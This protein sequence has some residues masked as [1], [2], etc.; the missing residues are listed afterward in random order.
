MIVPR[1]TVASTATFEG[2]GLHT[3]VPVRVDIHSGESGIVF[4]Y[5]ADTVRAHPSNVTDTRRCTRL[6]TI[7]TIEHLMSAL[8][9]TGVTDAEIELSAPELPGMDGSARPFTD[10][11]VAAGRAE[12][13]ARELPDLFKRVFFQDGL[14]K[15]AV[16]SGEGHWRFE[17]EIDGR[18]PGRQVFESKDLAK[19]YATAVAPA[20]TIVLTEEIELAKAA[21]LGRGLDESSVLIVGSEGYDNQAR[22]E[23]EIARHKLLDLIGD[24]YLCGVPP[25]LLNVVG[26]RSGH[27]SNI[28]TAQRVAEMLRLS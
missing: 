16:G 17:F 21:G 24:L 5:G 13:P 6:G 25:Q 22:F 3:G 23:D 8:A 19:E 7:S 9:G 10:G 14:V 4:R 11:I 28:K 20:R 1:L 26:E 2:V 15:V 27:S 12:L 18:W